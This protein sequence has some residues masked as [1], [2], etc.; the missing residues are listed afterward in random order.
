VVVV[1]GGF[2]A[3][4]LCNVFSQSD[5]AILNNLNAVKN[6]LKKCLLL[7]FMPINFKQPRADKY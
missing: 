6:I 4:D 3:V 2:S 1:G 5:T 7:N